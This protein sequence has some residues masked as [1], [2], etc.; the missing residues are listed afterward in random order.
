MRFS[1]TLTFTPNMAQAAPPRRVAA[2]PSST[3]FAKMI[4][5][6]T[7]TRWQSGLARQHHLVL[8][9]EGKAAFAGWTRARQFPN[10]SSCVATARPGALPM[11]PFG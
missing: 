3:G 4:S 6:T 8:P 7:Q 10:T 1:A 11:R 9:D 5:T 2:I